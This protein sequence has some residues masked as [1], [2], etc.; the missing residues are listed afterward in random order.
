MPGGEKY[1]V[2]IETDRMIVGFDIWPPGKRWAGPT[3]GDWHEVLYVV[4][5]KATLWWDDKTTDLKP[6]II[7]V[8]R[9]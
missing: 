3:I 5:G 6:E 1:N 4:K 8:L 7:C 2:T 9:S